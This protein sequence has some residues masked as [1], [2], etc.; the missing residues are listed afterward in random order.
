MPRFACIL[1]AVFLLAVAIAPSTAEARNPYRRAFFDHYPGATGSMLDDVPSNAGHCGVCHFDFDGSATRNPYGL[2]VEVR[3]AAGMSAAEAI[4]AIDLLDSDGDG[5]SN[6]IEITDVVNWSNTPT[7]PGLQ[8]GNVGNAVNVDPADLTG[9]LSPAGSTDTTPPTVTILSPVG[10]EVF[11]P[12]THETV[13][14]TATDA[15]GISHVDILL[16]DDGG[17]HW[18]KIA[19][20]LPPTGSHDLYVPNLPGSTLMRVEAFD[21][22][23]NPGWDDSP[24]TFTI[25]PVTTG[26]V[27]TSLRDFE[28]AGTQ[29]FE[30]GVL[31]DPSVTC[32]ACHG[33]YDPAVEPWHNWQGSM[34][35]QAMRDPLY[36]ATLEVAE[37]AVPGAGDLCL[38]C[39]T[40]G[41]WQ[42]G[43][44]TD[45]L[46][47][48][49]LEKDYQGVQCDYCHRLVDPV[50]V[51]GVSPAV[52]L[53][54]L[55]GLGSIPL[56]PANGQFV[57]DPS[58]VKRGPYDDAQASHQWLHSEFTLSSD[59]CATCHDVSNPAFVAG[60]EPGLYEV[61]ALDAPHPD[62]DKRNM[63]PVERT[64]SEWSVSDYASGGVYQP[65][66]AGDKPDGIVSTCQDCHMRDVTGVG[67]NVPGSPSRPD[68]GI[69]DLT[70]GNTFIPDILPIFYPEVDVAALQDGKT[71]ATAMLT[72]AAT[73]ELTATPVEGQPA[74]TVRITNETGHKLPSGYPEGRRAWLNVK[75]F[76]A[77][78]NLVYES[79]AY[80]PATG[81][82]G[83]DEDAKIYQIKPGMSSRMAAITGLPMGPSFHFALND[84]VYSD[85]RIPPR[86]F[87]NAAFTQVQSPPVDYVYAD[88]QY[89][90]DTVYRLPGSARSV[91]VTLYYQTTSKE[92]IEFLRDN[93][94]VSTL[95]QELHDAWANNGKSTPVV[96]A[97]QTALL[98]V[99][100]APDGDA[101]PRVTTLAQNYPN[102]F[103]PHTW[104][105]FTLPATGPAT[106][107]IYDER[108]RL[109]RT[110][111][112]E[113]V[114]GAGAHH[115]RWDG[116]DDGGTPVASGVY[117]YVLKT[118]QGDLKRKMTL[119]K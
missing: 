98:D 79:G 92:Y 95:G 65:Q 71:R 38:R 13:Q 2:D 51:E 7:F 102:P 100:G 31:D 50:Y 86:G 37:S 20:D 29:P 64:F 3:L 96:M 43:R 84:T 87:T 107:R 44:S 48:M 104:I 55:N 18:K 83:H 68:L 77:Q 27:P 11:D 89:W 25:N 41:G 116:A 54:I 109:V 80:D 97:Q 22:A 15:G 12:A 57:T 82:L 60:A 59:M 119:I 49:L 56:E 90:D 39:H 69:H 14:W 115:L 75:A 6:H 32:I 72:L 46:G 47:G 53:E 16:S 85:N 17:S 114:L 111:V 108:G 106:L 88:G 74:V 99:T 42:E 34:M 103:N 118:R 101:V 52:D 81:I 9:Y 63:F 1:A 73:M 33:E 21:N 24:G 66:F 93:N 4:A 58:P 117:H 112:D 45:T 10:G 113:G 36:R 5:F 105:D 62:G 30:G 8:S 76:D 110:L 78:D 91:D 94:T 19:G 35:A 40:P 26:I 61:Q 70:G 67:S 23:N 28:L